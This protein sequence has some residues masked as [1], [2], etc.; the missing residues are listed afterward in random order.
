MKDW[1]N[2]LVRADF[3]EPGEIL[4]E[5]PLGPLNEAD[6]RLFAQILSDGASPEDK[7]KWNMDEHGKEYCLNGA[8]VVFND[9]NHRDLPTFSTFKYALGLRFPERST[10]PIGTIYLCWHDPVEEE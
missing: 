5:I 10:G 9:L 3:T 8:E 1:L 2:Y 4:R 7:D 6:Q